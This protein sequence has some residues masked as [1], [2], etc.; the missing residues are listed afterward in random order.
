MPQIKVI[1]SGVV[2]L[3][4]CGLLAAV[5]HQGRVVERAQWEQREAKAL[6][7][8]LNLVQQRTA[9]VEAL[10]AQQTAARQS[11]EETYARMQADID[12]KSA[13]LVRLGKRLRDPGARAGCGN[14]LPAT[15]GSTGVPADTATGAELSETAS[16]FLF[17][18]TER[19]DRAAAYAT[20]AHLWAKSLPHGK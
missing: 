5:Y 16:R 10:R 4:V 13:D 11:A 15:S 7:E 6:A 8:S 19:C 3:L 1:V 12:S 17:T 9:E 2:A 18:L 20:A 14:P